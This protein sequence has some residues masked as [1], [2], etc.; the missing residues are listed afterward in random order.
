MDQK[1]RQAATPF[2]VAQRLRDTRIGELRDSRRSDSRRVHSHGSLLA[3]VVLGLATCRTAL[4]GV[5]TLTTGLSTTIRD[6]FG[7]RRRMS[8]TTLSEALELADLDALHR[9]MVRQVVSE[10]RRGNLRP[11]AS[12]PGSVVALD[13]KHQASL[14]HGELLQLAKA[15]DPQV[16]RVW[17]APAIQRVVQGEYSEVQVQILADGTCR[18]LIRYHRVTL[19]SH[20][21]FPCLALVSIPGNTN[22]VGQAPETLRKLFADYRNSALVDIVTADAG[23]TSAEVARVVVDAGKHYLLALKGNQPETE[24]EA[25]RLLD[26]ADAVLVEPVE[27]VRGQRVQRRL[28]VAKVTGQLLNF[29]SARLLLRVRR[30]VTR[31]DGSIVSDD[32]RYFVCSL[33]PARVSHEEL[34]E[35]VRS[36]W[37]CENNGH[38]V[39]D[40]ILG[41]DKRRL[42][43]GR[44]PQRIAAVALCRM[45]GQNLLGQ[46]RALS[47]APGNLKMPSWRDLIF[48]LERAL[49]GAV[50]HRSNHEIVVC[51]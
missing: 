37:R 43:F 24:R 6:M 5:E 38:L 10:H 36:H 27:R 19:T 33:D 29:P 46:L 47:R 11:M 18:G 44:T 7:I 45:I 13:G 2:A 4:R 17:D 41:E 50:R 26:D 30:T 40:A 49:V 23:N 48:H 35:L 51:R 15:I 21:S 42:R 39:S 8:D 3:V 14:S 12:L 32:S 31:P 1:P 16:A 34:L 28:Y 9:C 22:E 20:P 25:H